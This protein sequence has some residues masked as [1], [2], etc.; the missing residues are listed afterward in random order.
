MIE[1]G[2]RGF[3]IPLFDGK[4][5]EE[6]LSLLMNGVKLL[7]QMGISAI[8]SFKQFSPELIGK[9]YNDNFFKEKRGFI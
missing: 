1:D 9:R 8:Q 5:F 2:Q 6:K 4:V 7:E 3:L